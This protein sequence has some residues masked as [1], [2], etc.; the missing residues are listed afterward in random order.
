ME[1][2]IR[3]IIDFSELSQEWQDEA[4]NNLDSYAE[5]SLYLEPLPQETPS[6]HVLWSLYEAIPINSSNSD[7]EYNA[8]IPISNNSAMALDINSNLNQATVW[9]ISKE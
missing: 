9:F 8:I 2:T 4:K 5:E 7:S 3:N 1:K 6:D